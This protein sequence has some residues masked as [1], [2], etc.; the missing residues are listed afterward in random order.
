MSEILH[1]QSQESVERGETIP[2]EALRLHEETRNAIAAELG[3]ESLA[4][5]RETGQLFVDKV[6]FD[7]QEHA[8]HDE[9]ITDVD[10]AL[11]SG[12]IQL[13]AASVPL[14]GANRISL[15]KKHYYRIRL[16]NWSQLILI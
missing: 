3:I 6:D 8:P 15:P 5:E 1:N 13:E 2:T 14:G 11:I 16:S 4:A 9:I 12:G 10:A 7:I